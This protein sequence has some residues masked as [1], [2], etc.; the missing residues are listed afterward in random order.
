MIGAKLTLIN[1]SFRKIDSTFSNSLDVEVP[2]G[3][4]Q[5][6]IDAPGYYQ[7]E[8]VKITS[9]NSFIVELKSI[10][11]FPVSPYK[12]TH[13]QHQKS[14]RYYS[15][16]CTLRNG[17][18]E[19]PTF[20]FFF[21]FYDLGREERILPFRDFTVYNDTVTYKLNDKNT[22]FDDHAEM[23]VFS[24]QLS[25]GLYFISYPDGEKERIIPMYVFKGKQTQFFIRCAARIEKT[26]KVWTPDFSNCR[27]FYSD[28]MEF[29][30]NDIV[31]AA[32]ERLLMAY[33]N[34][35]Y[36]KLLTEEDHSRIANSSYLVALTQILHLA[37]NAKIPFSN[38]S[39]LALPDLQYMRS[40]PVEKVT[41]AVLSETPPILSFV[42]YKYSSNS[43]D[44]IAAASVMDRIAEHIKYDLFWSSFSKIESSNSV[45]QGIRK[46]ISSSSTMG[47]AMYY[48]ERL[49]PFARRANAE[50]IRKEFDNY[51]GAHGDEQDISKK[52]KIPL[53][54]VVRKYNDY[55]SE[56]DSVVRKERE[57]EGDDFWKNKSVK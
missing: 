6:R 39:P 37:L 27:I 3:L 2:S 24:A 16:H 22:F 8:Y 50:D 21:A 15:E 25:T 12:S 49:N 35:A 45:A 44:S 7:E 51:V 43:C 42:M 29:D 40:T 19:R 30:Y 17:L 11:A 14:A 56:Y 9:D 46:G 32:M 5:V 23:A 57:M 28:R 13:E 18:D 20:L 47:T 52:L 53:T 48:L 34:Y 1:G 33:S 31:Y 55:K 38:E 10:S 41:A 36:Y 4:Y 26:L 54:S